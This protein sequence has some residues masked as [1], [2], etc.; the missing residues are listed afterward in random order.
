MSGYFFIKSDLNQLVL[1]VD[2]GNQAPGTKVVPWDKKHQDNDNQLF[3]ED[4]ATG[5]IRSKLNQY[6]LDVQGR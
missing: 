6:C 3:Y 4:E 1:D 2:G 5:T